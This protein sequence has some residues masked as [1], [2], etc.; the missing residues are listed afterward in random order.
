M[1]SLKMKHL[2]P[3][4]AMALAL[5]TG[6]AQAQRHPG[7]GGPGMGAMAGGLMGGHVEHMLDLVDATDAQ[8]AQIK[9]IMDAA[10]GELKTQHETLRSLHEQGLTLFSAT[11]VDAAAIEALRQ[12][13]SAV[14][15][16][17]SRRMSQAMI[18]VAR[19]LTPE[20]RAKL[21]AKL[22]QRQARMAE[23]L[24]SRSGQ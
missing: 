9:S 17:V 1:R 22:K 21:A 16:Q 6:A 7:M 8:R 13:G 18:D 11:N 20:Q 4:A 19:V 10:R 15:E 12:K 14:H 2:I 24:K 3:A 5:V 23:H